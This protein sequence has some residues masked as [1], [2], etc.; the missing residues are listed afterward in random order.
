M[1]NK[2][3]NILLVLLVLLLFIH[4]DFIYKFIYSHISLLKWICKHTDFMKY[5]RIRKK[6][7]LQEYV[8]KLLPNKIH[9]F[10]IPLFDNV[11]ISKL[12]ELN[13]TN[14]KKY[15]KKNSLTQKINDFTTPYTLL[16]RWMGNSLFRT[17]YEDRGNNNLLKENYLLGLNPELLEI[18]RKKIKSYLTN[19]NVNNIKNYNIF[20]YYDWV[21]RIV[22]DIL[23]ILHF[24]NLPNENDV[25]DFKLFQKAII[26]MT[27]NYIYDMNIIKQ[28]YN[29][30]FF[31]E[32]TQKKLNELKYSNKKCIVKAWLDSKS[33][34][35]N[36]IIIEVVHNFLGMGINWINTF[37]PYL[38]G[39]NNKEIP[40]IPNN[41]KDFY[42]Y[43]CFRYL[44]PV[45]LSSSGVNEN[46]Q[47]IHDMFLPTRNEKYFGKDT[48]KFSI[49]R[50]QNFNNNI[51]S[52]NMPIG[53]NSIF[54]NN[55]NGEKV[56]KNQKLYTNKGYTTFGHGYRRCPG[57]FISM[58]FLEEIAKF[59]K[60]K[61][62]K[63]YLNNNISK[64]EE[65]IFNYIEKNYIIE[66]L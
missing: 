65:Y 66:F 12:D 46:D 28:I 16:G 7:Q 6:Y 55:K 64:K 35:D 50:H 17:N 18:Y 29:L 52:N 54:Y 13:Y 40:R 59:I 37:H 3:K 39:I 31:N 33:F 47:V 49:N 48:D 5:I 38:L 26:A 4:Y 60:N 30:K 15:N 11:Y 22:I 24:D 9:T 34:S 56:F 53:S 44:A 63:I 43:E 41:N 51:S 20:N 21:E 58:I 57:E 19:L 10:K 2:I 25:N 32:R 62:F 1:L 36:D 23:F 45:K 61:N 27:K 8:D 14:Y 42:L